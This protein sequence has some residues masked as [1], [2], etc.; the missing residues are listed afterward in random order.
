MADLIQIRRDT[1]VNWQNAGNPILEK[2]E[3][4]II[5]DNSG[6]LTDPMSLKI[7]DGIQGGIVY[8]SRSL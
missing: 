6:S 1:R 2:G 3:M 4:G 5:T 8:Q 7:G